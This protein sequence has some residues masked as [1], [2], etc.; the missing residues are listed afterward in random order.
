MITK[1]L[2]IDPG[3]G[4]M[5]FSIIIGITGVL[6]FAARALL[7][8]FKFFMSGGRGKTDD[9][10]MF[11]I[12]IFSEGK[13]YWSVFRPVCDEFE[14]RQKDIWYLTASPDDPALNAGY[15]YVHAVFIGEGNKAISRMN[16]I[17]AKVVLS[18]TP[19]LDVFQ[20]KR[21]KTA[22][23]YVHIPHAANDITLYKMFGLD[24]YDAILLSGQYQIDQIRRLEEARGIPPKDLKLAGIPYMDKMRERLEASSPKEGKSEPVILLAP[25]WGT[26]GILTVYGAEFIEQ[27]IKTGHKII[28]RPH[29]QSFI[30]EKPLMDELMNKFPES[31]KLSWNKDPDNFNVLSGADILISDFSGVLF[32]FSLVFNKPL[33]YTDPVFDRSEYDCSWDSKELWTYDIL[34]HIGKR[35]SKENISDIGNLIKEYLEGSYADELSKG[36]DLAREQTWCNQ[37]QGAEKV[38]DYLLAKYDEIIKQESKQESKTKKRL[39][40]S[41]RI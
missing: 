27:L 30:S 36:R 1:M 33:I 13:R 16:L 26:N 7:I 38:S 28:I 22:S 17:K 12:C 5:L 25:S 15:K 19:S 21:S 20:W 4:S 40:R 32:D 11:P 3:T 9:K 8:R 34:P 18:T 31:S 23:W 2:Y 24:F 6:V 41:N 35:L 37:G 29:P 10:D 14:K 39:S